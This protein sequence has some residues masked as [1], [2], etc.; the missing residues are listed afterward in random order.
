MLV[1]ICFTTKESFRKHVLIHFLQP[2]FRW[3]VC[4]D[5]DLLRE[6]VAVRPKSPNEW[7]LVAANLQHAWCD[8]LTSPIKGRSC[9]EH[10]EVLLVHHKA[11]NASAL[12]K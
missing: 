1:L 8:V 4:H 2:M 7:N 3:H 9:K 6:V 10:F 5:I 11:G 12:K